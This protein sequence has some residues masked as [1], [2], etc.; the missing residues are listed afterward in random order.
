MA[1]ILTMAGLATTSPAAH[2]DRPAI[3]HQI[4]YILVSSSNNTNFISTAELQTLTRNVSDAW[5]RMSRGIITQMKL[6]R[7][8]TL[9][10][11]N[12]FCNGYPDPAVLTAVLGYSPD[13]YNGQPNGQ[14]LVIMANSNE[15]GCGPLGRALTFGT[16]LLSGGMV[17]VRYTPNTAPSITFTSFAMAHELGHTFGLE[18]AGLVPDACNEQNWD[19]PFVESEAKPTGVCGLT[20]ASSYA[21]PANVMG[22]SDQITGLLNNITSTDLNGDQK[23]QL[24]IIQPGTGLIRT[25]AAAGEQLFTIH[26]VHTADPD[27]PQ[28]IR[29]TAD[30]P[31]GSGPCAPAVYNIDYDPV[32][33][34]V[35][36]YRIAET[37]DCDTEGI[38]YNSVTPR[39]IGWTAPK[40]GT[41]Q[42][43]VFLPGESQL[44]STGKVRIKV[45]SADPAAGTA[46]VSIRRTDVAGVTTLNITSRN[47]QLSNAMDAT[48]GSATGLVRTNEAGWSASSDQSW[49]S[50][51][52]SGTNGQRFTLS[53]APNTTTSARRATVTVRAGNAT[54]TYA[55][56]QEAGGASYANDC[57]GGL[58][59]Y[60][61]WSNLNTQLNGTFETD[62]DKDWYRLVAPAQGTYRFTLSTPANNP[63]IGLWGEVLGAD[64][65]TIQ[66][67]KW[68]FRGYSIEAYLTAGQTF[69][70]QFTADTAANY[71]MTATYSSAGFTV[72]PDYIR[73]PAGQSRETVTIRTNGDWRI[74][75][76]GSW[77]SASA[78]SGTGN[79]TVDLT[80]A[81]N[82][83]QWRSYA[84]DFSASGLTYKV[85]VNQMAT[86]DDCGSSTTSYCTWADLTR[87][88]SGLIGFAKDADWFKIIAPDSG[89][90]VFAASQPAAN[91]MSGIAGTLYAAD[92]TTVVASDDPSRTGNPFRFSA[93]LSAGQTY[94]LAVSGAGEMG[95]YTVTATTGE[96]VVILSVSH[97]S[98]NAAPGGDTQT[99]D[100]TASGDWTATGPSWVTLS[101]SYG[102]G[103]ARVR[104]ATTANTSGQSR[105]DTVTFTSGT[106]TATV[107]VTQ[108]PVDNT[109]LSVSPDVFNPAATGGAA[110]LQVTCNT[111]W[112]ATSSDWITLTGDAANG[113]GRLLVRVPDND[114]GSARAGYIMVTTGTKTV[115][116][117]VNQPA[118]N[119]ILTV[120]P[121]ALYPAGGGETQFAEV[122]ASGFWQVS[123]PD[124]WVSV[125]PMSGTGNARVSVTTAAN[126]SGQPR[127][128][129]VNFMSG[130]KTA[131]L[132]VAQP[133]VRDDCG[134]TAASNCAWANVSTP[135]GGTLESTG[136][137]DWFSFTAPKSGVY[138]FTASPGAADPLLNIAGKLYASD[139]VT[140]LTSDSNAAPYFQFRLNILMTGGQT[141]YLEVSGLGT[142]NYIVSATTPDDTVLW[143][144]VNG[145]NQTAQNGLQNVWI[146]C[147][148]EWR[149]TGPD[150]IGLGVAATTGGGWLLVSIG[151]NKT[152][153][154]RTGYVT[155]TAGDKSVTFW[156]RQSA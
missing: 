35:R 36:V 28:A 117:P 133:V 70:L 2:A 3:E 94:Y 26:D 14:D 135:I 103:N 4:D 48:G 62:K 64:G 147:N 51:T 83:Q 27:L 100:V 146:T 52:T 17:K 136:D 71:T 144:S 43:V 156:V 152:G 10:N 150:W 137:K 89:Q 47:L 141:Y 21:D 58:M 139:G 79:A 96:P 16:G 41:E 55:V 30:D 97:S 111:F 85:S 8:F 40:S 78:Q 114:T 91:G 19:G 77:I 145:L 50:V 46:T 134:N 128:G 33:G 39:T 76:L 22:N 34:G 67:G 88:I 112:R 42:R 72:S 37:A 107:T 29:M 98:V 20:Q 75:G 74:T 45:V 6:G 93:S 73:V 44:N 86:P 131:V 53:V 15:I 113:N 84:V 56:A 69:F 59:S 154:P 65:G 151:E 104:I 110:W 54:N 149:A 129:N 80:M 109:I 118:N 153:S 130:T 120:S 124:N 32:L 148:R 101:P 138:S 116:I 90:W 155:V 57:G 92:G 24:G 106:K 1:A 105:T 132:T 123:V 142:G 87:P 121:D 122:K 13:R 125:S 119:V 11:Y 66:P 127:T 5:S 49:A 143:V 31:D 81:A 126:T 140:V 18:H 95:A 7:V 38:G 61:T 82:P 99:V 68:M 25:T 23:W 60:C 12:D 63:V 108:P 9:P 102:S 115:V